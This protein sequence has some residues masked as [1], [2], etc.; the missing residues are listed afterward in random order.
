VGRNDQT[1]VNLDVLRLDVTV[2]WPAVVPDFIGLALTPNTLNVTQL[3]CI[4]FLGDVPLM[5][6]RGGVRSMIGLALGGDV[7]KDDIAPEWTT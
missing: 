2:P 1:R 6:T 4:G 5:Y 3:L 7:C